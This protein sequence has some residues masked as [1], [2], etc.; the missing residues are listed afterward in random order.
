MKKLLI[1]TSISLLFLLSN[2]NEDILTN[3]CLPV[4]Y[5]TALDSITFEYSNKK[6]AAIYY[7]FKG[8]STYYAKLVISYNPN[9]TISKAASVSEF[10]TINFKDEF[11]YST[12]QLPDIMKRTYSGGSIAFF[13]FSHD[14]KKR[15]TEIAFKPT[16]RVR[17]EYEQDKSNVSSVFV[18]SQYLQTPSNP[19]GMGLFYKNLSFDSN[20]TFYSNSREL[21]FI[22]EYR[23]LIVPTINNVVSMQIAGFINND[24]S[25][26]PNFLNFDGTPTDPSQPNLLAKYSYTY[27]KRGNPIKR[28]VDDPYTRYDFII[29]NIKYDCEAN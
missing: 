13:A 5:S 9:G 7:F 26:S 20:P 19:S 17:Y 21:K 2:C 16:E 27:D 28:A 25:F 14:Q 11:H 29:Q 1:L 23:H 12:S 3:Q 18:Y 22:F 4:S 6:L 10:Q 8:S 24:I 15:L